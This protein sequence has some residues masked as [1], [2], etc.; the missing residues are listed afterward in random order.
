MSPVREVLYDS[1]RTRVIR[2]R[3]YGG[4][5]AV[6]EKQPL[7]PGAGDRLRN[8]LAVLRRLQGT[9]GVPRLLPDSP[10]G[11][12]G[13]TE[14]PAAT[15]AS[16]T[17]PLLVPALLDLAIDLAGTLAAVH[18]QG[19]V[20][21]DVSPA[22]VLIPVVD[23][24]PA[25][26]ARP[27]LI[28][29]ELATTATVDLAAPA[30]TTGDV[31]AGTL[32]Y[33]APEQTGRTGRPVD[34]RADLYAFGA[35]LYEAATGAPPFGR[36]GDPLRLVHD[37]LARVPAP[38]IR[39]NPDLP[40]LLSDIILRLLDKEPDQR[41]QSGE[42]LA[43]DLTRL[44]DETAAFVLGE[45]DFPMRLAPPRQLVG[46]EEPLATLRGM[47]ATATAGN[48]G[49]A[50]IT[51]PPGV[52][53]TA[54]V[55]RLRPAVAAAG[56]RFVAGKFDQFRR[57]LGADAVRQAFCALGDQL[58]AEPDDEVARLR[59]RLP[60]RLGPNAGLAAAV[61]PPFAA[62][63][64]VAPEPGDDDPRRAASRLRQVGLDLLRAVA[65][66]ARPVTLFIDD[67]QWASAG[68]FGFLDAVLA[69]PDLPGVLILGAFREAEVD[70]AHPLTPTLARLRDTGGNVG[71]L[72]LAN[73]PPGDLTTLLAR[74]LRLP[75]PAAVPLAELLAAH[76]GGNPFDSVEMVN[77]LR[78]D[79][80]LVPDGD[81]W[82]WDPATA[83]RFVA[84]GDVVD[85]L[86]ARIEELP[87]QTRALLEV[88][89][90]LGGEVDLTLLP[91]AAGRP[92]ETVD[93]ELLPAADEGL[94]EVHR[95]G[96]P[97]ACFRHDRVQQ[98]AYARLD[99][100]ARTGLSLTLARRLASEPAYALAAAR[101]YL[102]AVDE[103]TDPDE[104]L[105][106]A[107]LLRRAAAAARLV[108]NHAAAQA[109]LAAAVRLLPA[110]DSGY[111]QA[112]AEWHASLCSLGR[113]TEADEVF[114][115][116][117][118]A[119]GDPVPHA[120][121]VCEQIVG[122]TNRGRMP[123]A[124]ELGLRLLGRLGV[125]V[126]GR[127]EL[128]PRI[129][130]G[131]DVLYGWLATGDAEDDLARP[132]LTEPRQVAIARVINRLIPPAFFCDQIMM[133]W[134]VLESGA[135]WAAHG[136]AAALVGPLSHAG[137]VTVPARGD[138]RAGYRA[139]RRVLA[140]GGA[141]G[142][143]PDTS[144]AKFLH[145]LGTVAWF[146]PV[147]HMV[148]IAREAHEGLLRGGDLQN[149]ASTYFA[150]LPGLL[151]AGP[152]LDAYAAEADAALMLCGRI[153]YDHADA[154]FRA[155]RQL[156]RTLRGEADDDGLDEAEIEGNPTAAVNFHIVRSVAAAVLGE[157]DVLN[158][159][160]AAALTLLPCI[161]ATYGNAQAHV[162]AALAAAERARTATGD[163]DRETALADL[164]LSARFLAERAVDQP[165]NFGHLLRLAD[166]ERAWATGDFDA[167]AT[168]YDA[169]V[170][171]ASGGGSPWH[172]AL[173]AER[174][175]LFFDAHRMPHV[176]R[177]M[178]TEAHR[179]YA[180]WRAHH[181][182]HLLE[183]EHPFLA[184]PP[185]HAGA[186]ASPTVRTSHSIN[187]STEVIDLMAVLEAAR[188]L[189]SETDLDRLRHRVEQVLSAMTG[190]TAVRVL[191]RDDA[192]G[193]WMLPADVRAVRPALTLAE[194]GERGL[195]P[196]TAVRYADRTGEP[197][198]VD[199]ATHDD[200]V[201]RD[202]YLAGL[203]H[204]S[205]LVVPV[206]SQ[207]LPRAMLVL[208]NRLTRQAFSASRLDAVQLIAGQLTV[209]LDNALVYASLERRVAERTEELGEANRR[210]EMLTLTDPLT[211][212]ANRRRLTETLDALWVQS[213][214]S[215]DPIGLAMIDIDHFKKYN[216]HYGHQGGDECLRRVAG[217]L[218]DAVRTTDLVARYGG[219][220]FCVVMP[221][222]G[223][224][225]AV[226]VAERAVQ[227]VAALRESHVLADGGI[228]T[229][230][231][232]VTSAT[233]TGGV[234]PDHL[235]K[236][237]DEALY[238][239]KRTGRNRVAAS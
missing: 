107:S 238:E 95:D 209:S 185:A 79:G 176:S 174:A 33:L 86:G 70:A 208:E 234:P 211:G 226:A 166:A 227:A 215:G 1:D 130:A 25:P 12:V 182:V 27:I 177:Q 8:E 42:G 80:V 207:G 103:L 210:L 61:L 220:E 31:I 43:Y 230:S 232:G 75:N 29:F 78:R 221:A 146:E 150:S 178:L 187:L 101:L 54:L 49:V 148:G 116:L 124:L 77:A 32:A 96:T 76:T 186:P 180:V 206:L 159:H 65:S 200:R 192:T 133:A 22:N 179:G 196:V 157:R 91:I 73:L 229:I 225:G 218:R 63:L 58:L 164:D 203:P 38:P 3:P 41:Y 11:T 161:T 171:G 131:L 94:V 143:E 135:L 67:L 168:A 26:H 92:A 158:R 142:W 223:T 233:P 193:E 129:G 117:E 190:A 136:P 144:Q 216:D 126:P 82:R 138:Y 51:G 228:V 15:L 69:E 110:T 59:E 199:D 152:D 19:V 30:G 50:L 106:A 119:G 222:A 153:G 23:G 85:L 118:A 165:G 160:T 149:A 35:V 151:D 62:L 64:G 173:I 191:L 111:R 188:A 6:I 5:P 123:D 167:A 172:A 127:D 102:T 20:H 198:L 109:F 46:R 231:V 108:V 125:A 219:E 120:G 88:M 134:L 141:R 214:R 237:A 45:R 197:M 99:A 47:L 169:A 84:R 113:F 4:G 236:W 72:P 74:M 115:A 147:Q 53:K 121:A 213:L 212:L 114:Q 162:L 66:S 112:Q 55:D 235:I 9:L 105:L 89:A 183:R 57:D 154:A 104:R 71:E 2:V 60:E 93:A 139:V 48:R 44:R 128:G 217:A 137:F 175:A 7:G 204:C 40:P 202:P 56:G 21:R 18:R 83:R 201:A 140:V 39:S 145:A 132:E 16:L 189:S 52:G 81:G 98:A 170:S 224:P 87:E 14:T 184:A 239:A 100:P 156:A 28:D 13:Y 205:L 17:L 195:L 68:A 122:L 37:H 194:A 90:C 24:E 181:K 34:H 163:G 97:A 155:H 36:D 10:D